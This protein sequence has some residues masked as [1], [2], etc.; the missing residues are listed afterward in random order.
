MPAIH[1]E[2]CGQHVPVS[3]CSDF[4]LCLVSGLQSPLFW[5]IFAANLFA[6]FQLNILHDLLSK[7]TTTHGDTALMSLI[8]QIRNKS[9]AYSGS[10]HQWKTI[11]S[12]FLVTLHFQMICGLLC[13]LKKV[14][15]NNMLK[16]CKYSEWF[17]GCLAS[18]RKFPLTTC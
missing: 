11:C 12:K 14:S 7:H 16:F 15:I 3:K 17:V 2:G 4:L 1:Q 10:I 5:W 6:G 18:W 8:I 13:F 9:L